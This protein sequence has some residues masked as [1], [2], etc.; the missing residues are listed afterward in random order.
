MYDAVSMGTSGSRYSLGGGHRGGRGESAGIN[1]F[2]LLRF[3]SGRPLV[4]LVIVDDC[5]SVSMHL[6][7]TEKVSSA[8]KQNLKDTNGKIFF[9][10][11]V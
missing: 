3:V 11:K 1:D 8:Y 9:T 10:A 2:R 7:P 5:P 4:N 6:A